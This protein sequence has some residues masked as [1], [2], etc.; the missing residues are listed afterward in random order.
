MHATTVLVSFVVS[1]FWTI[2][3][4]VI[5]QTY[6]FD[7]VTDGAARLEHRHKLR[8]GGNPDGGDGSYRRSVDPAR[9]CA[10]FIANLGHLR[11]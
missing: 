11:N 7:A 3:F 2:T 5:R 1:S 9:H 10:L 4:L 8:R 6:V